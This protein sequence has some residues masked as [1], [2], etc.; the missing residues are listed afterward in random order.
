MHGNL[1]DTSTLSIVHS[2]GKVEN[3]DYRHSKGCLFKG[4]F[5]TI[6]KGLTVNNTSR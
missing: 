3:L 1:I 5:P 4:T 6:K 2:E